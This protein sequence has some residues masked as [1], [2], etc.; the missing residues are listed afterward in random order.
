[1]S[2]SA[3]TIDWTQWSSN[4]T[5]TI[6]SLGITVSYSGEMDGLGMNYPSWTPITTFSGGTIGNPPMSSFGMIRELGGNTAVKTASFSAPVVNPVMAIWSLGQASITANFTFTG[7]EPFTIES[8]GPSTEFGGS[9]IFVCSSNPMTVCGEKGNR[10]LHTS[11]T[12]TTGLK[13]I[14]IPAQR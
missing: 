11:L 5:G 10:T 14:A 4:N 1:V 9:S 2:A 3:S 13:S 6:S 12:P 7:S 8:G